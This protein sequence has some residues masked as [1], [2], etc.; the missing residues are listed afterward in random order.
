MKADIQPNEL[1]V[2]TEHTLEVL[3]R[4][5]TYLKQTHTKGSQDVLLA[6]LKDTIT[7]YEQLVEIRINNGSN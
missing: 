4:K 7:R 1:A 5:A 2:L 3:V 6:D